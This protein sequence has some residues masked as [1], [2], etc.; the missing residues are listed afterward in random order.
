MLK[1]IEK[2][3][4][5]MK[6]INVSKI[7]EHGIVNRTE[8]SLFRYQGWPSVCR[9]ENGV[10]YV[11]SSSFRLA[12]VCPFGKT[13]MYKSTDNGKTWSAPTVINDT[14][15]DDRD[16]GILYMG[17]GRLLV[18]WFSHPAKE[19]LTT[20]REWIESD[21]GEL[22]KA[23]LSRYGDIPEKFSAGGSFVRISEDYGV[24]WSETVRVP[25]SS[26]HGPSLCKDGTLIYLGKEMYSSDM[27]IPEEKGVIAS[28]KSEDGGYTWE[29]LG[30][31]K[32]PE[33][34]SWNHFHEPHIVELEDG[35]LFGMIRAEGDGVY[36]GFTVYSTVSNDGGK[37]W[38]KWKNIDVSGSPPHLL[39]HSSGALVCSLGRRE[40]PYGENAIVSYDNGKTWSER[41]II[42]ENA[43]SDDLGYPAS[44]E[45]GDGSI[46]TVY[47]Q[48]YKDGEKSDEFTS[49]L[50]TKWELKCYENN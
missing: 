10:L 7:S 32:K 27:E 18:T 30:V 48:Q 24:T 43:D 35:T 23:M 26:P 41:Y 29:K 36:H 45:L 25:V 33:N 11:V 9:D 47:Y 38:S 16:A 37:T 2:R 3:G 21:S 39:L 17:N 5:K 49:V 4:G 46:L 1:E 42:D 31:L 34:I 19:Y 40:K 50:F 28:Y 15:L 6:D 12:H 20:Y 44:V 14:Y 13:A 22:G 8:N